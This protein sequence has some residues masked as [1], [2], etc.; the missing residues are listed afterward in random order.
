MKI[1][2]DE[3]MKNNEKVLVKMRNHAEETLSSWQASH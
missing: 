2:N 1:M 3:V